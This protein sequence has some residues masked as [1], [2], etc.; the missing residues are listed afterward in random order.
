VHHSG[1][2]DTSGKAMPTEE[3]GNGPNRINKMKL[4]KSGDQQQERKRNRTRATQPKKQN[5]ANLKDCPT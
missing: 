3:A 5:M 1:W 4:E 2:N